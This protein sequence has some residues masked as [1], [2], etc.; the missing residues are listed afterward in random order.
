MNHLHLWVYDRP[1]IP[2]IGITVTT[3]RLLTVS[4]RGDHGL[5]WT[6]TME[7]EGMEIFL[8]L[9]LSAYL[10]TYSHSHMHKHIQWWKTFVWT[11]IREA[12]AYLVRL[13]KWNGIIPYI[14]YLL[15]HL[16]NLE[17]LCINAHIGLFSV[18][19]QCPQQLPKYS[20]IMD[21]S[22]SS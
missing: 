19:L 2:K 1:E 14:L 10:S 15:M 22:E 21:L 9:Y 18:Y 8:F 12:Y 4:E 20:V 11:F 3:R 6:V 13:Q 17:H 7:I 5:N 16:I